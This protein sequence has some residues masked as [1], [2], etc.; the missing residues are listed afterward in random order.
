MYSFYRGLNNA[1]ASVILIVSGKLGSASLYANIMPMLS[2]KLSASDFGL[3]F[4]MLL[5][6]LVVYI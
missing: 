4:P 2:L 1:G 5:V 3:S 6:S